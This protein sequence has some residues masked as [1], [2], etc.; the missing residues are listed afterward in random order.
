MVKR[1][2]PK[3]IAGDA[4]SRMYSIP[5]VDAVEQREMVQ[6]SLEDQVRSHSQALIKEMAE[7]IQKGRK[8]TA[9]TAAQYIDRVKGLQGMVKEYEDILEREIISSQANLEAAM[10]QALSLLSNQ[11]AE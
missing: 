7:I 8:V 1:I 10:Q 4:R 5:V 3:G 2:A 11:D 6:E 9:K